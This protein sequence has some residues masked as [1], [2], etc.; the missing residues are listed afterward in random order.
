MPL[1]SLGHQLETLHDGITVFRDG[2]GRPMPLKQT[3]ISVK[4]SMGLATVT[5]LRCFRNQEDVSIEVLLTMPVGFDAVVTGL[6]ARIDGRHLTAVAKTKDAARAQYE[7]ALD[8]GEMAVLHEEALRGVHVLSVGQLAP[9]K[10]VEVE[11]ETVVALSSVNGQPFLRIPTTVGQI[12]GTSPLTPADDLVTA[13]VLHVANFKVSCDQGLARLNDGRSL[14]E[15][16]AVELPLNA[17][18]ELLVDGGRF[19]TVIGTSSDGHEQRLVLTPLI[20]ADGDL[21]LAVLIDRS[22]STGSRIGQ[23]YETVWSAMHAGLTKTFAQLRPQDRI[24]LWQFDDDCQSLGSAQGAVAAEL[25]AGLQVAGG[26]TELG[27]AVS[28]VLGSG[29][30]DILVLT[31]GQTW[32]KTVDDLAGSDARMSAILIGQGSLDANIGHLCAMTGG[33]MFYAP[34]ADVAAALGS[35]FAALRLK[36]SATQGTPDDLR[37]LRG[38]V[39]LKATRSHTMT[40]GPADSIGRFIAALSLPLLPKA[41][42]TQRAQDHG[43]CTHFTSLVLVDEAGSA[44]E[45][46]PEMR[47]VPL[48]SYQPYLVPAP[49]M[50]SSDFSESVSFYEEGPATPRPSAEAL[51]RLQAVINRPNSA[52][53]DQSLANAA[54]TI[55]WAGS[56]NAILRGDLS[57]LELTQRRV[58]GSLASRPDVI[59]LSDQLHLAPEVVAIALLARLVPDDR[60]A[61]R[62]LRRLLSGKPMDGVDRIAKLLR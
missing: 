12:Y 45:D 25:V 1:M 15:G 36:G 10:E 8:R 47:K 41:E 42:A 37:C 54:E 29:A 4:I 23:G 20:G 26:G 46:L 30:R 27:R 11:L 13:A 28:S 53:Q 61:G 39:E 40:F 5:T 43:L 7:D 17:A 60:N 33:Q 24:A 19:G 14:T 38:G 56:T 34:G 48:M 62:F 6:G 32:A 59:A 16:E 44:V 50:D 9:G 49:D 57:V 55:D 52:N 2:V 31:D 51:R 3:T 18:I 58:V 21:D 35:A 22:G